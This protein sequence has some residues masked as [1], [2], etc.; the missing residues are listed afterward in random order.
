[1]EQLTRC[2]SYQ[3]TVDPTFSS[4]RRV[5][6]AVKARNTCAEWIPPEESWFEV[7]SRPVSGGGT[8]GREVGQFQAAIPPRSSHAETVIEI[9]CPEV[10]GCRY[11][12]SVWSPTASGGK[13]E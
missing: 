8:A 4:S 11:T 3:A 1:M 5:R 13:S 7:V 12:V 9:D 6:L 10:G 2:L